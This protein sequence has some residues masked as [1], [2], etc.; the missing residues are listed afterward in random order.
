MATF[1]TLIMVMLGGAWI[2][3]FLFPQWL[4]SLTLAV[5]T[6]WAVDGLDA[7]TW[8]G[9]SLDA[10]WGPMLAQLGFAALFGALALWKFSR[11]GNGTRA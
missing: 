11:Q 2:P 6:R 7:M 5:P 1:A 3:S 4:Q 10:A 8:R 9:L